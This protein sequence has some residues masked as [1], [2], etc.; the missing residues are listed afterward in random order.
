MK[1]IQTKFLS[2]LTSVILFQVTIIHHSENSNSFQID[3]PDSAFAYF[4]YSLY[5][6]ASDAFK[7][8]VRLCDFY[9]QNPPGVYSSFKIKLEVLIRVHV[10]KALQ[11][12]ATLT[13]WITSLTS[14]PFIALFVQTPALASLVLL[15][16]SSHNSSLC[17]GFCYFSSWNTFSPDLF[18]LL[19]HF[20]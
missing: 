11:D 12:I 20:I 3:L 8:D 14:S 9:T 6:S 5:P 10:H 17:V 15:E 7:P 13:Y 16:I 18:H 1:W 2:N 4:N 19:L